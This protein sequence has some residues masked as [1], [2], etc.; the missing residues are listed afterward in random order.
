MPKTYIRICLTREIAEHHGAVILDTPQ[1]WRNHF[2]GHGEHDR[3][4]IRLEMAGHGR[5]AVYFGLAVPLAVQIPPSQLAL[6]E[7]GY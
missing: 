6:A 7:A 3:T 2:G 5:D 1:A 4:A